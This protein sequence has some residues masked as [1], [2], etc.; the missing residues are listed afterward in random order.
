MYRVLESSELIAPCLHSGANITWRVSNKNVLAQLL[1]PSYG[2][3]SVHFE[4]P[5]R[6]VFMVKT[7]ETGNEMAL[8]M[9]LE[10]FFV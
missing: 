1:V 10:G 5:E 2:I 3:L 8:E 6:Y 9:A 7:F 4:H